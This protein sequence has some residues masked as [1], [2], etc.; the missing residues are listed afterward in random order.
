MKLSIAERDFLSALALYLATRRTALR[1]ALQLRAPLSAEAAEDLRIHYSNYFVSLMA[2]TE[3]LI[4]DTSVNGASFEQTLETA[5]GAL[6]TPLSATNY[7]Y[8]RELRNAIVHRGLDIA[9]ATH[10][11]DDFPLLVAPTS[12]RNRGRAQR[13][14]AFGFYL[15]QVV[16]GCETVVGPTIN[17]HLDSLGILDKEPDVEAWAE[18]TRQLVQTSAVMPDWVRE[19]A[20]DSLHMSDYTVIH[21]DRISRLRGLLL[22]FSFALPSKVHTDW[23]A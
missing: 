16:K 2:A 17:A 11:V 23:A 13:Y 6:S 3:L 19:I 1:S 22:P 10:F 8:V 9:S 20:S 12:V 21:H 14:S 7:L 5:F 18:E 4:K 15:L